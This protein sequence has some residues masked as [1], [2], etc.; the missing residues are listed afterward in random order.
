MTISAANTEIQI[1]MINLER[2]KKEQ[3]ATIKELK[4]II[5]N[6]SKKEE[7][8]LSKMGMQETIFAGTVKKQ[9]TSEGMQRSE[10]IVNNGKPSIYVK[11]KQGESMF[12]LT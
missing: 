5:E 9:T 8:I 11:P 4:E 12:Q 7:T 10:K 1:K 6:M 2:M 3:E